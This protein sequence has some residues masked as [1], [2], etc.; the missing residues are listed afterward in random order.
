MKHSKILPLFKSGSKHDPSN[1]RPIS[2]LPTLCKIFEKIII[3]QLLE[4]FISNCLFHNEQYGFTR[5]KG[6]STTDACSALLK[7]IFEAW[8]NLQNTYRTTGSVIYHQTLINKLALNLVKTYLSSR[9]E[10]VD[11]SGTLSS[12]SPVMMGLPQVSVLGPYLFLIYVNDLP[13]LFITCVR[14]FCFADDTSLIFNLDRSRC[15][16]DDINGSLE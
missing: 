6:S 1:F 4:H 15:N 13:F 9:I 7:H 14:L 3:K 2:V 11:V 8:E 10:K 12:G 5:T 16:F